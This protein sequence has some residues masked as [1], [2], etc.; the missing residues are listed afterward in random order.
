M[1]I[2]DDHHGHRTTHKPAK[3]RKYTPLGIAAI[4]LLVLLALLT[5][6]AAF[7]PI[8]AHAQTVGTYTEDNGTTKN[9]IGVV[10]QPGS[11]SALAITPNV[12]NL[13][14]N[15]NGKT[16]PGNL[17]SIEITTAANP[18]YVYVFN[19]TGVPGDGA[20]TAGNASGSYQ[21]CQPVAA[22]TGA[23]FAYD[24]PERYSVGIRVVFSSTACGTLTKDATPTFLKARAQ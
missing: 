22:N 19:T 7:V 12:A 1:S 16:S 9:N 23:R 15:V 10:Q 5:L 2:F 21:F 18:G 14:N 13:S 4:T 11:S 20:V 8:R 17:Y 3:P 6:A 24:P